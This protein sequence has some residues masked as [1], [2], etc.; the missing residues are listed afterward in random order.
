MS[1]K[2]VSQENLKEYIYVLEGP[3]EGWHEFDN[4]EDAIKYCDHLIKS[5]YDFVVNPEW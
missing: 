2:E 3:E 1:N 4:Y 5:D